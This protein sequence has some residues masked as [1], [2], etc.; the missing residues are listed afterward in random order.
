MTFLQV[1]AH[2]WQQIHKATA[3]ILHA[4]IQLRLIPVCLTCGE[5]KN[6]STS[7]FAAGYSSE[8]GFRDYKKKEVE[9][10]YKPPMD[11]TL[12]RTAEGSKSWIRRSISE[13]DHQHPKTAENSWIKSQ[14]LSPLW[15]SELL[16]LLLKPCTTSK[17]W[18][19]K[20]N[21][22]MNRAAATDSAFAEAND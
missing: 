21:K 20:R 13:P 17:A 14:S 10:I 1:A 15:S 19:S 12:L 6:N 9:V 16:P 7:L 4:Y 3:V 5:L 8:E 22:L 2:H 18:L 11:G